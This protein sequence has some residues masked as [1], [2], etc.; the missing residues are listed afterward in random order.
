[1]SVIVK[2][3]NNDADLDAALFEAQRYFDVPPKPGSP[4]ARRFDILTD[5]I[6]DY[7][8]RE[9]TTAKPHLS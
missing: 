2:T 4:E 9:Y 6:E 5:M 8:N 1:M 3:I 7:E